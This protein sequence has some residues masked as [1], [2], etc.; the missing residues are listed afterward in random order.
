MTL[1]NGVWVYAIPFL[2]VLTVLVF[3]HELGHYWVARRNGVR[4][5]VFSIGFGPEIYGFNDKAGTRWRFSIIPLGGYVKMFGENFAQDE[6]E[7]ELTDEEKDVSFFHKR[8]GQRAAIVAAG[9][10]A[11]Y[12]LAIVLWT[13]L[14]TTS[15]YPGQ[16]LAGIGNIA[17]GSAA[18]A[19]KM[20]TG[21]R[22][23]KI[24]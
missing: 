18:A 14:F 13:A 9:P 15:G 17:P 5:E 1:W 2:F 19:A 24:N 23:V 4:I 3:F 6:P 21:D 22:I 16:L 20:K 11:N 8:L 12:I 10:T 7:Q